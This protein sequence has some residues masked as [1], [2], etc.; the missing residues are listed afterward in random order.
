MLTKACS[1]IYIEDISHTNTG[2]MRPNLKA[3]YR[4]KGLKRDTQIKATHSKIHI[5]SVL[6]LTFHLYAC[7]RAQ[8]A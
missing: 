8:Y 6:P 1:L 2:H 5:M 7:Q 3:L 4:Y